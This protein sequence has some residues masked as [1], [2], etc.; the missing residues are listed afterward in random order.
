MIKFKLRHGCLYKKGASLSKEKFSY[1]Q[2]VVVPNLLMNDTRIDASGMVQR[3][4]NV[5]PAKGKVLVR[6]NTI[7]LP[8]EESR[9]VDYNEFYKGK[10]NE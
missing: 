2:V 9:L 1:G 5:G 7:D 6:I 4:L 3:Y 8:I 10:L